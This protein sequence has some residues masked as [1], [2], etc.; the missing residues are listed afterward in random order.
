MS[1]INEV[2]LVGYSNPGLDLPVGGFCQAGRGPCQL[3]GTARIGAYNRLGQRGESQVRR[4]EGRGAELG[5]QKIEYS[6]WR[7]EEEQ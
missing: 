1:L 5:I 7:E 6:T 2:S 4:G 3:A